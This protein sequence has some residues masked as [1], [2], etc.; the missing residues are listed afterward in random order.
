[1][2]KK[3]SSQLDPKAVQDEFTNKA[4]LIVEHFTTTIS[5]LAPNKIDLTK[6]RGL[7][8]AGSTIKDYEKK[9]SIFISPQNQRSIKI[10]ALDPIAGSKI[11][12]SSVPILIEAGFE[13]VDTGQALIVNMQPM[14]ED[15]RKNMVKQ[16]R[17]I[18]EHAKQQINNLRADMHKL[19]KSSGGSE[20]LQ[21]TAK[22]EVDK[23][24][25]KLQ[26]HLDTQSDSKEQS[27]LKG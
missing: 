26:K 4:N 3:I 20:D 25:D 6:V 16:V 24:K 2:S 9:G 27:I 5:S 13:V 17:Q 19:I 11:C 18:K 21:N 15:M 7:N 14:T 8:V 22:A 10:E 12:K 23:I 1:M